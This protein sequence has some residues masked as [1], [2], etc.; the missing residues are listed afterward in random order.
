MKSLMFI[1]L[2]LTHATAMAGECGENCF[3][4]NIDTD[5]AKETIRLEIIKPSTIEVKI[6]GKATFPITHD[7]DLQ[8]YQLSVRDRDN[9]GTIDI[10]VN[11]TDSKGLDQTKILQND[12]KGNFKDVTKSEK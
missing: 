10:I 1:F 11:W 9:N 4:K 2:L 6:V 7:S 12:G 5:D 3:E 8:V